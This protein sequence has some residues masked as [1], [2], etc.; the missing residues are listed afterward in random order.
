[1]RK[2]PGS[3]G[4][5]RLILLAALFL[6]AASLSASPLLADSQ[7]TVSGRLTDTSGVALAGATILVFPA[8][9]AAGTDPTACAQLRTDPDGGFV[10]FL[11]P[12]RYLVA[13]VKPG[14]DV[15]LTEVHSLASR[16]LRMRVEPSH[17][18]DPRRQR[19]G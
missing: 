19:T 9:P 5:V 8:A 18:G 2:H 14:Y 4:A 3:V 17:S 15:A 10:A 12:G 7:S 1:M 6:I 13:A 11:P 16:V